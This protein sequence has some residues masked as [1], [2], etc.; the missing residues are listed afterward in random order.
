MRDKLGNTLPAIPAGHLVHPNFWR[1]RAQTE[2]RMLFILVQS[3]RT[4][5]IDP[6]TGRRKGK[7]AMQINPN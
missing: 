4:A 7:L 2:L 3:A 5:T 6:A 1:F